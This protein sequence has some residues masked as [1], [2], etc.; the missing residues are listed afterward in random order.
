M[1]VSHFLP[2]G[3]R[4]TVRALQDI[5]EDF[6]EL[7]KRAMKQTTLTQG[8]LK[9]LCV[10]VTYSAAPKHWAKACGSVSRWLLT[11]AGM[12]APAVL[13]DTQRPIGLRYWHPDVLLNKRLRI[14]GRNIKIAII[15]GIFIVL[16]SF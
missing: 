15:T 12:A 8:F 14:Q 16:Y 6:K 11:K 13:H 4:W 7:M 5:C 2:E 10:C 1:P 3:W 9:K